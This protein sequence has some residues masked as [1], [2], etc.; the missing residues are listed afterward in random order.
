LESTELRNPAAIRL[1]DGKPI[2]S[3]MSADT[4]QRV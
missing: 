2:A 4:L 3:M 1:V